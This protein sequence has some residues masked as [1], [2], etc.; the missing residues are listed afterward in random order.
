MKAERLFAERLREARHERRRTL[1]VV[2]DKVIALYLVVP[3]L[4]IGIGVYRDEWLHTEN[5]WPAAWPVQALF[6]CLLLLCGSGYLRTF[7]QAADQ[8]FVLADRPLFVGMR[9]C[10]ILYSLFAL[11][12]RVLLLVA[13]AWPVFRHIMH[14]TAWQLAAFT[15]V[16]CMYRWAMCAARLFIS[17]WIMRHV[18]SALLY[19]LSL[20]AAQ[21]P[22]ASFIFCSV[23][24]GV[25][26]V[27]Y[28]RL[29]HTPMR[30]DKE[31]ENEAAARLALTVLI[32]KM[33]G[34]V[35]A[36]VVYRPRRPLLLFRNSRRLFKTRT[37]EHGLLELLLK[38][39]LRHSQTLSVYGKMVGVFLLGLWVAPLVLKAFLL[40][41]LNAFSNLTYEKM[42]TSPLFSVV[43]YDVQKVR[44][45]VRRTFQWLMA[46]PALI[47]AGGEL[48]VQLITMR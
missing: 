16:A 2:M 11:L 3:A 13:I 42:I 37:A 10:A 44:R 33:S 9:C 22:V 35:D 14:M 48:L 20:S 34:T 40:A 6:P 21:L 1:G 43:P 39:S 8:L 38:S 18:L 36:P 29:L 46:A 24:A 15:A 32:L 7:V 5:V 28:G 25:L 4:V 45:S 27:A 47:L 19:A 26:A 41:G 30:F 31:L 12:P 17:R 23:L